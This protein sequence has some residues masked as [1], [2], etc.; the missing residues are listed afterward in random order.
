[1]IIVILMLSVVALGVVLAVVVSRSSM[2]GVESPVTTA[3]FAGLP[4]GP[5][6]RD[7]LD[8]VRID[9]AFR[10]Y[11]MEQVDAVLARLADEIALRDSEIDRLRQGQEHY[12]DL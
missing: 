2:P 4:A 1:V 8:R 11:R 5:V 6:S 3:S 7:A 10:G 12:G 9:V